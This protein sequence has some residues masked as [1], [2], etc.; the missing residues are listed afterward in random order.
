ME[1]KTTEELSV[2]CYT[3]VAKKRWV[4]VDDI[5]KWAKSGADLNILLMELHKTEEMCYK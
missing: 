3:K 5:I 2:A 4:A 1:I